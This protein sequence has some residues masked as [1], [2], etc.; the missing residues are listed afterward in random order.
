MLKGMKAIDVIC[1]TCNAQPGQTCGWSENQYEYNRRLMTGINYHQ[2]R[3]TE[4]VRTTRL[5]NIKARAEK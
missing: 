5:A 1:P 4:A 2:A 3:V